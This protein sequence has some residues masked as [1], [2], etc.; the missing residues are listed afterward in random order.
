[1]S[2]IKPG[3]LAL[4]AYSALERLESKTERDVADMKAIKEA[5]PFLIVAGRTPKPKELRDEHGV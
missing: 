4:I 5:F 1:M 3:R 2:E